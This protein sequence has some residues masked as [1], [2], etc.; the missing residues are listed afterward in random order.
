MSLDYK[1]AL[2]YRGRIV[3]FKNENGVLVTGRVVNVDANGFEI[4]EIET[5]KDFEG[6][7]YGFFGPRRGFYGR[8]PFRPYGG[9]RRYP[10]AG[11]FGLTILPF[12][13]W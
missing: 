11:V 6:H 4:E 12:L 7:G 1:S 3:Q 2:Q 10:F 8:R 5:N 13:F 9:F